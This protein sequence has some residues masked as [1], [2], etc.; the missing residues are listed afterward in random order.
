MSL[1]Y[2]PAWHSPIH[3]LL[4][5]SRKLCDTKV[6]EPCVRARLGTASHFC[7]VVVLRLRIVLGSVDPA[8]ERSRHMSEIQGQIMVFAF[9]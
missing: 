1:E 7:E 5:S 8:V 3:S 9:R 4:L 2:E 6:Y